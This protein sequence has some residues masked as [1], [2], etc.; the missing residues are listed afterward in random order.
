MAF[1]LKMGHSRTKNLL[2]AT[3]LAVRQACRNE[4]ETDR[5][6]LLLAEDPPSPPTPNLES[7]N[8]LNPVY[9]DIGI[10]GVSIRVKRGF[11]LMQTGS[12]I[13]HF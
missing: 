1:E 7:L 2:S 4:F 3:L 5:A 12:L 8:S 9:T 6:R 13:K 11:A 10:K